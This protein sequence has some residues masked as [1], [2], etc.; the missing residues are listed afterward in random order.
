MMACASFSTTKNKP[1]GTTDAI[2]RGEYCVPSVEATMASKA[3][4][5]RIKYQSSPGLI[6]AIIKYRPPPGARTGDVWPGTMES[7]AKAM[8]KWFSITKPTKD[9]EEWQHQPAFAVNTNRS[10]AAVSIDT[11]GEFLEE[12]GTAAAA[13]PID[14]TTC[15]DAEPGDSKAEGR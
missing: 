9:A 2:L 7:K 4:R 1:I 8:T 13:G 10:A 6:S 15:N 5:S 12:V 11:M 3:V 14:A